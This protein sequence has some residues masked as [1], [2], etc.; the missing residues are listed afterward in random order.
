MNVVE[1]RRE[2]MTRA[3]AERDRL[4]LRDYGPGHVQMER[5]PLCGYMQFACCRTSEPS[6]VT[7]G[8]MY[9]ISSC[10]RC[11]EAQRRAP[12]VFQWVLGVA[13]YLRVSQHER[14]LEQLEQLQ[15][16]AP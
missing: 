10:P 5:C 13:Q 12:E 11:E 9:S 6:A 7:M 1:E 14:E 8:E 2:R 16:G 4:I 15:K 3:I